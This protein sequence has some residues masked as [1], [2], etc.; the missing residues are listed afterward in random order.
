M[1]DAAYL[2]LRTRGRGRVTLTVGGE[3]VRVTLG[4]GRKARIERTFD[5]EPDVFGV[6][7]RSG[8]W[9]SPRLIL[10]R[11]FTVRGTGEQFPA[12]FLDLGRLRW[13]SERKDARNLVAGGRREVELRLPWMLLGFADPSDRRV[14]TTNASGVRTRRVSGVRIGTPE[15]TTTYR[16]K[17]WNRVEWHERRK[18]GWPAVRRA[19]RSA[20]A[21]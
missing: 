5:P 10:S 1:H 4:P 21:G 17:R 7:R 2:Y 20:Q 14:Y 3:Q 9:L 12:E 13:G 6:D 19:F 15:R 11:P 18:A 8:K 16:W